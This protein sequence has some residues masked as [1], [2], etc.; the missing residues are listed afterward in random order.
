MQANIEYNFV[1]KNNQRT[2]VL[3]HGTGGDENDLMFL[4]E[5]I[6]QSA[7]LL[8]LR[9]RINENGLNRFFKRLKPGVLD[10]ENLIE[11]TK[12]LHKFLQAFAKVNDLD[13]E[14]M[15]LLGYSNGANIIGSLIYHFGKYYKAHILLHPMVPI[16]DFDIV[17]QDHN[18]IF[19]SAGENDPIVPMVEA[20]ELYER[21][22]DKNADVTFN[23]YK[24][25]HSLSDLEIKDI[26]KWYKKI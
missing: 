5:N 21:L 22:K 26:K 16:K 4:G 19:I 10:T 11:E 12:Y 24:Y 15:V 7:N 2:L 1:R 23:V 18:K 17:R 25:G 9:G 13:K 3:L 20:K 6:D 14:E 8:G